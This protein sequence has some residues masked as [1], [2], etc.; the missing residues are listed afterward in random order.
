MYQENLAAIKLALQRHRV[1]KIERQHGTYQTLKDTIFWE[2][3]CRD[4]KGKWTGAARYITNAAQDKGGKRGCEYHH[5]IPSQTVISSLMSLGADPSLSEI[6][7]ILRQL[8]VAMICT[9]AEHKQLKKYRSIEECR[10]AGVKFS[11]NSLVK[12]L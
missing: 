11:D 5:V 12:S 7:R 10:T 9:K 1:R 6:A 3:E 2:W 4:G 8:T